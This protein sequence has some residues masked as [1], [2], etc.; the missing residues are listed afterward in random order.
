MF[1]AALPHELDIEMK[2]SGLIAVPGILVAVQFLL[3]NLFH[4]A[5]DLTR[6]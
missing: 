2:D 6:Y 1:R 3:N 4:Q 5:S